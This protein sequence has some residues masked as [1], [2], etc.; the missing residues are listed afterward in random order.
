[1]KWSGKKVKGNKVS[2]NLKAAANNPCFSGS[3]DI[4]YEGTYTITKSSKSVKVSFK[5][6]VN[7]FPAYESYATI[8]GGKPKKIFNYGPSGGVGA[9]AGGPVD[10]VK[11]SCTFKI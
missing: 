7:G 8:N 2:F 5:G 10:A 6:K 4:D 11:G 9:L 1:M 3:F